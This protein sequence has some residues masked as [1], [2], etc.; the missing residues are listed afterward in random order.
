MNQ[1]DTSSSGA[2]VYRYENQEPNEFKPAY[3]ELSNLE[4]ISEH[5]EQH[6]GKIESVFHE[7]VS[8]HVHI[9][10]HW[11]K[12]SGKIPFNI[13]VT[14][15]M[16]DEAMNTPVEFAD[17]RYA[18]L[19]IILPATWQIVGKDEEILEDENNYWPIRWLKIIARFPHL[20]NTWI[21]WGHTIPNGENAEPFAENTQLGCMMLFPSI[22][23]PEDFFELK[24][25]E[26]KNI[27]FYC[28]IPL[29]KEEM[30]FKLNKG[31]D[32]L[33]DKFER[34]QVTDVININRINTCKKKGFFGLW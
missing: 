16:S 14:S 28:L 9:D 25:N 34:H 6:L 21:G 12:P 3:G 32:A 15:G 4:A 1:P 19:C 2:P 33:T 13:L 10:I 30:D 27:R 17:H 24:I 23:L 22:S 26:E 8:D 20:Y 29:Y 31:S 11:V 5:I 7:I 18:E